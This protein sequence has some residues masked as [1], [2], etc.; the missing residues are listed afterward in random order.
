VRIATRRESE[1]P[2]LNSTRRASEDA[3]A[4]AFA[5][6]PAQRRSE[7]LVRAVMG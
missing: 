1:N 7:L 2:F 6:F 3:A 5:K 4:L